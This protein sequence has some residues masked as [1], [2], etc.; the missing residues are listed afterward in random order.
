MVDLYITLIFFLFVKQQPP[1]NQ[2]LLITEASRSHPDT[3]RSAV[4]LWNI[5][6][7]DTETST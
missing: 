5:D 7:F 1:L 2:G 6:Q 4:L 3:S